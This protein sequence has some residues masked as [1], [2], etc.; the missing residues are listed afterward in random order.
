[1]I[2]T[3]E[4]Y[5]FFVFITRPSQPYTRYGIFVF[6]WEHGEDTISMN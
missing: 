5:D 4:L 1:M 3:K 6:Y 2:L